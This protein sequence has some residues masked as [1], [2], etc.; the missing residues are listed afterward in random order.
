MGAN[1]KMNNEN[2]NVLD[3]AK[4]KNNI[5]IT[6]NKLIMNKGI[7]NGNP[8]AYTISLIGTLFMIVGFIMGLIFGHQLTLFEDFNYLIAIPCW[9]GSFIIGILFIGFAEIIHLLHS[10]KNKQDIST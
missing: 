3:T 4:I 9:I 10:I 7:I 2:N 6:A 5:T 1:G 8:I